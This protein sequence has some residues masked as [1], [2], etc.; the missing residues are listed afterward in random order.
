MH[1]VS[2]WRPSR[3]QMALESRVHSAMG[4]PPAALYI[5][6]LET[7]PLLSVIAHF[8]MLGSKL[9]VLP[10]VAITDRLWFTQP[11]P[12]GTSPGLFAP[13]THRLPSPCTARMFAI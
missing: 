2:D 11:F 1:T 3:L 4:V 9:H 5:R 13:L 7:A 8:W 6:T 12:A 10:L